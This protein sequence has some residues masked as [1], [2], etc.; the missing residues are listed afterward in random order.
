[1]FCCIQCF[2]V[3]ITS[4]MERTR[5]PGC[6]RRLCFVLSFKTLGFCA[7]GKIRY[8][9][10]SEMS[11]KPIRILL[12][13]SWNFSSVMKA[14]I[15]HRM[16]KS[17]IRTNLKSLLQLRY[18]ILVQGRTNFLKLDSS[19][20]NFGLQKSDEKPFQY[21]GSTSIRRDCTEFVVRATYYPR[22][23][24]LWSS[25]FYAS[26]SSTITLYFFSHPCYMN[27]PSYPPWFYG[28]NYVYIWQSINQLSPAP[29]Y[30]LPFIS[31]YSPEH[32]NL[33]ISQSR[34]WEIEISHSYRTADS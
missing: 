21:W 11:I 9:V 23:L 28:H 32:P 26:S 33:K 15:H 24:H 4:V 1:M 5:P 34:P 19:T 13:Y 7:C 20:Q 27:I 3:L 31:K 25:G 2:A 30:C 29:C 17:L 14:E 8:T 10:I 12:S 16:H 18:V 6:V 22:F